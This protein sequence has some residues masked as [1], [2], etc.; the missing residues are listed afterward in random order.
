[1]LDDS[2]T[3]ASG[4]TIDNCVNTSTPDR[5]EPTPVGHQYW[6][7]DRHFVEGNT[8]NLSVV[9]PGLRTHQPHRHAEEEFIF[10]LEGTGEFALDDD[11][12][13]VGPMTSLHCAPWHLHGISNCGDKLLKY[14]VLRKE[15]PLPANP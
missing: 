7:A 9:R 5:V 13:V 11:R 1:M 14:L 12:R 2:M 10:V 3:P 15:S 4:Y 6:F 8:V